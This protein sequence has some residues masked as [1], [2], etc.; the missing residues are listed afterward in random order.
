MLIIESCYH[1]QRTF[2]KEV[3]A[4]TATITAFLKLLGKYPAAKII[5]AFEKFIERS[6]E[7]PAPSDIIAIITGRVKRDAALY[8]ELLRKRRE[9]YLSDDEHQ[10]I[11][12]YEAQILEDWDR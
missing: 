4:Y 10:Y 2:G 8:R 12:K 9:A 6:S 7:F 1:T 3:D 5:P 11:R